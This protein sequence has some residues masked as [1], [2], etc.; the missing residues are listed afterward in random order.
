MTSLGGYVSFDI[1]IDVSK[2]HSLTKHA[3]SWSDKLIVSSDESYIER[4]DKGN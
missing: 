2:E 3:C 4:I 1:L